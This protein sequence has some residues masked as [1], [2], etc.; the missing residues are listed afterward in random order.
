MEHIV[1]IAFNFDDKTVTDRIHET[2]ERQV[3]DHITKEVK[4]VIYQRSYY[5]DA[6][7]DKSPLVNMVKC[8]V[9]KIIEQNKEF[10]ITEAS[11]ILADKLSRTKAAKEVLSDTLTK[12]P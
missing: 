9:E 10:I 5:R 1:S 6:Y 8:E 7:T 12:L 3:V 4:D 2:V 11:K